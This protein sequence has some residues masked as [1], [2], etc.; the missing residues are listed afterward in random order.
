MGIGG[1]WLRGDPAGRTSGEAERA[2][3]QEGAQ[4]WPHI[5]HIPGSCPSSEHF[6]PPPSWA[7]GLPQ[8]PKPQFPSWRSQS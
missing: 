5:A 4:A 7:L 1:A 6:L 3:D 8:A 2:V